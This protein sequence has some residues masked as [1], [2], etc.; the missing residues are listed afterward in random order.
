MESC[1]SSFL[2]IPAKAE[3]AK[4]RT[5]KHCHYGSSRSTDS[6]EPTTVSVKDTRKPKRR[7]E[8]AGQEEDIKSSVPSLESVLLGE[9]KDKMSPGQ[10][11]AQHSQTHKRKQSKVKPQQKDHKKSSNLVKAPYSLQDKTILSKQNATE[12]KN[13]ASDG[14][15]R[16]GE[17][18]RN[19]YEEC[20]EMSA[21][22]NLCPNKQTG[23]KANILERRSL[24]RRLSSQ[25]CASG[26]SVELSEE[27]DSATRPDIQPQSP[28]PDKQNITNKESDKNEQHL[29]AQLYAM[30]TVLNT[31]DE[32]EQL[33]LRNTGLTDDLLQSLA[34]ALKGSPSEV[35]LL[36]LNL[37]HIGPYGVSVLLDLL[38]AKP[39][40]F[41]L[42]ELD[43][44]GNCLGSDGLQ[45]LA[46]YM[47]HHSHLRYLGLAQTTAADLSAWKELFDSLK[48]NNVLSKIILDES[49]LGDPGVRL[50]A[51]VLKVN[52][53]LS[54][55]DLDRNNITDVN[56]LQKLGLVGWRAGRL[57]S[58]GPRSIPGV[59]PFKSGVIL[60]QRAR[61]QVPVHAVIPAAYTTTNLT[62]ILS[63]SSHRVNSA[64]LFTVLTA[65]KKL[66]LGVQFVPG[67][68]L[69][70]VGQKNSVSFDYD[71][72]DGH[73]HSMAVEIQDR[74]VSLY[75][76]CG[77]EPVHADLPSRKEEGLDPEGSFLLGKFNQNSVQFEGAICQLDIY[78]SAKA[79]H[80]Y[81][82]YINKLCR[83]ADTYRPIPPSLL[84][85][86]PADPN[87][88]V[89]HLTP[90]LS[91][92]KYMKAHRL[93]RPKI[94]DTQTVT[95]SPRTSASQTSQK[96]TS[97]GSA[98]DNMEKPGGVS[99]R[100]PVNSWL[101]R[102]SATPPN[103]V[104]DLQT[105]F[106]SK[107]GSSSITSSSQT[108][109]LTKPSPKRHGP[110]VTNVQNV[111][112]TSL[113]LITLAATD[114]FQTFDLDPTQY[115]LLAGPPGLKGE[116]GP[117]G[118]QGPPGKPG[119]PGRRGPRGPAGPHGNPGRPGP[120][121]MKGQKGEPG[122]S[123]GRASKGDKGEPGLMGPPGLTGQDG[124]KGQKGHP[125]PSGHPG[126]PGER[127]AD[128]SP[129]A[130]GYPGRQGLNGPVG[131]VGPKGLRGFIGIPGLFGLPGSDGERGAP[132]VHGKK[133]KM[134][135]PGFPGS[136]GERGP[137]GADGNPGELGAPGPC[138]VPGLIGD[139][140]PLGMMGLP[141]P[142]GLKGVPG[143]PGEEGLKGDKGDVGLP[144]APGE[145]GFQGDKGIQGGPGLPGLR[146]KA[147]P[148]GNVGD[149]GPDGLPGPPGP[150]GFPG[151]IG[152]PG[153]NGPE[154]P[155]G[156]P[157]AR[158][159]PG[160]RGIAGQEG[161]VGP[162]GLLGT[163]GPEG[164]PGRQGFPGSP[165]PEGQKGET[166]I[167]G[168]VGMLGE[169]GLVGF[170]GAI[171]ET[172][173]AG[174]KG[175]RGKMGLPGPPG[176]KGAMGHPGIPGDCGLS[177]PMG[178]P[179]PRGPD[180]PVGE[181]GSTGVKGADGPPGISGFPGAMGNIGEP[182]E[183]GPK[184]FP[185]IP[186]SSGSPGAKGITGEPG[187]IG[188]QGPVGP[189]GEMGLKGPPGK[190]GEWGLP[191]EPGDKGVIGP[192]GIFGEPGLIGPR[193]EPGIDGE[194]GA[195]ELDGS[196][197]EKGD[198]GLE[199]PKGERGQV[200]LKGKDGS[201]GPSGLVGVRGIEGQPGKIGER[202][203][204]GEKGS[205]GHQG[206]L[207]ETG[208][209][210]E[211]GEAGFA[212]PKGSRGTIGPGGA[213][214]RMGLQGDSGITGYEG[215][216]GPQGL[217]GPP[218]L[219]GEKGEQGGDSKVEG[220]PG[221]QGDRGDPGDRGDRGEP[222][223]PGYIGQPGVDGQRGK[224]GSTGLHGHPG[225]TGQRGLKGSKGDQGQKGKQGL[226]GMSGTKGPTGPE[227]F[228][229][230]KGVVGRQG[231]EGQP[232]MDGP[233]G[234]DGDRGLKGEQGEDGEYGIIGNPG[235]PGKTGAPG[236]PGSQG[237]F[238]PK[239]ER[240]LPGQAGP[241][242][243]RGFIGGMGLP[244][245]QGDKGTKGQPGDTGKQG[246]P[247]IH[248]MLGPKGPPG[249]FGPAGIPG[250]KGPHGLTGKGGAMGPVG[251]IGPS[252]HPGPQ[253]DKGSRGETGLQGPMGPP[254]PRGKP[255]PPGL[256]SSP[257]SFEKEAI[258][259]AF[260]VLIDSHAALRSESYQA[261]DLLMLDQGT[262]I[263][264]TLQYLSTLI[265]SLK[266]PLGT[267]HN[268]A[269]ICRDLQ[270]CEHVRN[271]GTYWI[272]P[273]LGC[274]ADTIEVT[275]NFSSGGQT[276]LRPI[277]V[278]KLEMGVGRIQM[279]FLHL[280]SSEATQHITVHCLNSP[281]WASGPSLA[282]L[283]RAVSFKTWRGETIQAGDLLEP[284]VLRDDCWI[285]D[286]SWH[287]A[288]F[289]F[290]T[291]DP[292][293]LPIVDMLNLPATEADSHYH[294]E[295]GPVCFL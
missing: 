161:D 168:D 189:L 73:W 158:G 232:G 270:D 216:Q 251:I 104:L 247:G 193:G 217:L 254:G 105:I 36:N 142:F 257:L 118:L 263:L 171:G 214:G 146:G 292:N 57:T 138:G 50:L 226:R 197:G 175:D 117:A 67:K 277:T 234:K 107:R 163:T 4:R 141:G 233:T 58:S 248:G 145:C 115:S 88:T 256:P 183:A 224:A 123:P 289:F 32:V 240:G 83:E 20:V 147:G 283:P 198:A 188:P 206:H 74:R 95:T 282:F 81:C 39:Q 140:G 208:P 278:S 236:L 22:L 53:S 55:V 62:L 203:K 242:G 249:D 266:N 237:S 153:H 85:L 61:V 111:K 259:A 100:S 12:Q 40:I 10:Q 154:G 71:V 274:S 91:T 250:P 129:G 202:G 239:G 246:F 229:G 54:E 110:T 137:P 41:A 295:V 97:Y 21:G 170:I 162:L 47:R 60:T 78:P 19:F 212:G 178:S 243:K 265:H 294:L 122:L 231:L 260:Q 33:V 156:K 94:A 172:G 80:N 187:P 190:V 281:V 127:G 201:T 166:G 63:L 106:A 222:G 87:I 180:G 23:F 15:S 8:H 101:L 179:G 136:F 56:V 186:G 264:K 46:A 59:I 150:E 225:P 130:K 191:G 75:T 148:Q 133:G 139:M 167:T 51:D 103:T 113:T 152:A 173:L 77:K 269:R 109:R 134:G 165:G 34:G 44:G 194:A 43:I 6:E 184:G 82:K 290:Q 5:K 241:S 164:R 196:K 131:K 98:R 76:S 211:Q 252:G 276:C 160:P 86:L 220:P 235:Q 280:L 24:Q 268:P 25:P 29:H 218:G 102:D 209:I 69:V 272:D 13:Q 2:F 157:G 228:P 271:D 99:K 291:Q 207:G 37:N 79:A 30:M 72:H 128:G 116:P 244:G 11:P 288:H 285:K 7:Q 120:P 66:Q 16:N 135:R 279:N 49:N 132:G 253:G 286:G 195:S 267:Q 35:T 204:P 293:L 149:P 38:R 27:S 3:K 221:P 17:I 65:G 192:A 261:M 287:Q 112:P 213:P 14:E 219:K 48:G 230:P 174:E 108:K 92:R 28:D 255:G 151:D 26:S 70:Y 155:K 31:S 144:G 90:L 9:S 124:R 223:D 1:P 227:G 181:K 238:G 177:G 210:G 205:K 258:G 121:G 125:G 159:L 215:H 200:G 176:E 262:D 185:G 18:L 275:C 169:R 89:T 96:P 84:S 273:N 143:N 68:I 119:Q 126:D 245:K 284:L 64:F 93:E 52:R 114:G 45:V 182:G 199:G 42:L